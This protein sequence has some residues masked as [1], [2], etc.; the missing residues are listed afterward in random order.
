MRKETKHRIIC[1]GL[2]TALA[3]F[4][5]G[6]ILLVLAC[7]TNQGTLLHIGFNYVIVTALF[8]ACVLFAIIISVFINDNYQWKA[9][10]TIVTMLLNIPVVF[11]YLSIFMYGF[12]INI[13]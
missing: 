7:N 2:K 6:T 4:I 8:N 3:S 1:T 10:F 12:Q 11:I 5:L 13:D 9:L